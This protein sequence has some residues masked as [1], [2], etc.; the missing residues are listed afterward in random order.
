M[1]K[2][3]SPITVFIVEDDPIYMRL[4][5]YVFELNPDYNI[6][7]FSTGQECIE[8]LHLKPSII[9]LDFTLPDMMGDQV[10]KKIKNYNKDIDVI[11]LSG[12][13]NI[14]VAVQL[15]QNGASDY[16]VKNEETK[17]RL[18]HAVQRLASNISLKK[19][20]E[21]LKDEL[22]DRYDFTKSIV[23]NSIPMQKVYKLIDKATKTNISV[24]ITGETGSGKEVIAKS[25][26]Y[27]STSQKGSFVAVNVS[28]IPS[29]LIESELFG[30]EK[31]AFTGADARKLG[32]FELADKGTLFLDEIA[33]LDIN[34]QAKLLRA[35]QEREFMRV[36][37]TKTVKFDARIIVATHR[38][39]LA[40]VEKGN[41]REDLYYRLLGLPI[42]VPPLRDRGNDILLLLR[43]FLNDFCKIN[44]LGKM[45][46]DKAAKK[47]LHSY[48][49]PGNV[50][51]L[52][53]IVELAAVMAD[54]DV[55][56]ETDINFNSPRRATAF[57][58]EEY[59]LREYTRKIIDHFLEKYNND[60]LL[61]AKKLNI[62]KSTIY[63]M[64]KEDNINQF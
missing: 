43:H 56:R 24:S 48:S 17:D 36:G 9:S 34:L 50:R 62:G 11:I 2:H 29:E 38:D 10:L 35:L 63:R 26:H 7:I 58:T 28:A 54:E 13:Q 22:V 64:L 49:Y 46:F 37:G 61:V 23:G 41:F 15:L 3:F 20:V 14:A 44:N 53:A 31:G 45:T 12:Q 40:E 59:S 25:I 5:K 30:H 55:I 47:K 8:N 21:E 32:K 27:N 33:E 19:E 39:L 51:E 18:I 4:V 6:Y 42:E 52:K 60:V 57:L 1:K 16:I